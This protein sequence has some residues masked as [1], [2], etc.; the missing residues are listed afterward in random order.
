MLHALP[1]VA[2][3]HEVDFDPSR[4]W[5][6]DHY[7]HVGG[8]GVNLHIFELT[9]VHECWQSQARCLPFRLLPARQRPPGRTEPGFFLR[10]LV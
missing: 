5:V 8:V 6:R 9:A 7:G 4:L 10:D 2:D 3:G 1:H